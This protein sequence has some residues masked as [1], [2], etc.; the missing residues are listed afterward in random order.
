MEKNHKDDGKPAPDDSRPLPL[1]CRLPDPVDLLRF[2]GITP[3]R[4]AKK[5]GDLLEAKITK[6]FYDSKSGVVYSEALV[7]NK[8]QLQAVELGLSVMGLGPRQKI[9]LDA[10]VELQSMSD[11]ELLGEIRSVERSIKGLASTLG[12]KA[13][14][15][16]RARSKAKKP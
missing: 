13:A 6:V 7:D 4:L 15:K 11:A 1:A 16:P 10:K 12:K 5:L 9:E 2:N 3:D 14:V 8:T